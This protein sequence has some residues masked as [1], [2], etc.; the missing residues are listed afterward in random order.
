MNM[1]YFIYTYISITNLEI[2]KSEMDYGDNLRTG[3][4]SS[5]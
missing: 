3:C 2:W 4:G 1:M 5:S